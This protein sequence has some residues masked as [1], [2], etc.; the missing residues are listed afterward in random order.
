M[1]ESRGPC[2]VACGIHHYDVQA[3]P[4]KTYQTTPTTQHAILFQAE[5]HSMSLKIINIYLKAWADG[6]VKA[7]PNV[8]NVRSK[9]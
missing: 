8:K 6:A 9:F 4:F 3:S 1:C 7:K 5:E 2:I